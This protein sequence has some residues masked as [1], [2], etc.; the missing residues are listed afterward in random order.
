MIL[1]FETFVDIR[2]AGSVSF[3]C[4]SKSCALAGC[5]CSGLSLSGLYV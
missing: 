2:F 5:K 1:N 4:E 3:D